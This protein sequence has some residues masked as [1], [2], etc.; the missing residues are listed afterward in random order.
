MGCVTKHQKN[1]HI[2]PFASLYA[3]YLETNQPKRSPAITE[4]KIEC[5]NPLWIS[6]AQTVV[7]KWDDKTSKSG[8][9]PAMAPC[10]MASFPILLPR[11]AS[12][13]AAPKTICV[14][15]SIFYSNLIRKIGIV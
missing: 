13:T 7:V 5:V 2:Q 10:N 9:V 14:N 15:E 12:P 11:T 1:N 4:K 3:S 6:N 8:I